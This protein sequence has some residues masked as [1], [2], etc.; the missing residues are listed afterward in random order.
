EKIH[1][2]THSMGGLVVR[3][4]LARYGSDRVG[5]IVM[6]ATPNLG[7]ELADRLH[8]TGLYRVFLGPA[9]QQL[10]GD[11]QGFVAGLAIPE[12]PF[13]VI[14]GGRGNERGYNPLIAG[15]NDG[16]VSV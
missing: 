1:F 3:T 14:A 15:D 5:R 16:T 9:G 8:G 11:A 12:V 10:T 7:A 6:I 2:V 4:Y 13:G